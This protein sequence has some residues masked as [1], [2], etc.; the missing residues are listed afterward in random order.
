MQFLFHEYRK[1]KWLDVIRSVHLAMDDENML[2]PGAVTMLR[3]SRSS[4]QLTGKQPGML[5]RNR[6]ILRRG[7]RLWPGYGTKLPKRKLFLGKHCRKYHK[8]NL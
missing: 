7:V 3:G 1:M 4:S 8:R 5:I 6:W 2:G